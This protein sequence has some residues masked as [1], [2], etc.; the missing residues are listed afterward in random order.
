LT[1]F[2]YA[3]L[4][5]AGYTRLVAKT[6]PAATPLWMI[7]QTHSFGTGGALSLR[8]PS[9]AEVRMQHWLAIGEGATG[10]FWFIYSSQQ[11]W[12]G[13]VDNPPL[14][15][16]VA[17]LAQRVKPLR[18]LLLSLHKGEDRF[19]IAGGTNPYISTLTS[20]DGKQSYAVAVNRDCQAPQKLTINS[21]LLKGRLRD[22]ESGQI[23]AQG[24]PIMLQPGDGRIFEI[25]KAEICQR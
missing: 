6:K 24:Q 19:T 17:A 8:A 14:Y 13:L 1:G 10:I 9:A 2:G 23:Y 7:L 12:L 4:D 5:F 22:L 25:V 16:E 20:S 11:G 3:D 15:Q 21:P 18:S